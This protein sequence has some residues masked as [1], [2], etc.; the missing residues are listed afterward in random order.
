MPLM[1]LSRIGHPCS[2]PRLPTPLACYLPPTHAAYSCCSHL[3]ALVC[4]AL[5][6]VLS[7]EVALLSETATVRLDGAAATPEQVMDAVEACGFEARVV[8]SSSEDVGGGGGGGSSRGVE[9]LRLDVQGMHC[10]ACSS[11]E[12][13]LLEGNVAAVCRAAAGVCTAYA[14]GAPLRMFLKLACRAVADLR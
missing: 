8:S 6:G 4:R 10:S 3:L 9:T 2:A 1:G 5:P 11:G 13:L 7:A 14:G 12:P